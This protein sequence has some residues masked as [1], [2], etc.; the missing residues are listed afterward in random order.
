V[1]NGYQVEP[2][3]LTTFADFLRDN[4]APA[5]EKA[6]DGVHGTNAYD[7][8]AFG[9]FVAQIL[10][11]PARIALATVGDKVSKMH[12]EILDAADRT[13]QAASTYRDHEQ[14]VSDHL[15]TFDQELGK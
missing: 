6:S 10:A 9:F 13:R 11:V 4:T 7:N 5:V 1:A 8:N 15:Q 12:Q 3:E 14:N 2:E